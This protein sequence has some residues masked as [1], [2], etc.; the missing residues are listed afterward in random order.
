MSKVTLNFE[1]TDTLPR[2]H[3]SPSESD[4]NHSS[5]DT[6]AS[7]IPTES[8]IDNTDPQ[9]DNPE[10]IGGLASF[11]KSSAVHHD[12]CKVALLTNWET[13]LF[14]SDH[15]NKDAKIKRER[16]TSDPKL[17]PSSKIAEKG[18]EWSKHVLHLLE[19][20]KS[21]TPI[22]G[23]KV[24]VSYFRSAPSHCQRCLCSSRKQRKKSKLKVG[25]IVTLHPILTFFL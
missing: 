18:L 4:D 10:S 20:S 6:N 5:S 24:H 9:D 2:S 25:E 12:S 19:K 7:S 23:A 21:S 15:A 3:L 1:I 16:S 17:L 11:V 22:E 8:T 13:W 14:H